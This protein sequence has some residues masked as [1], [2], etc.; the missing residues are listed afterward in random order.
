MRRRIDETERDDEA[1]SGRNATRKPE[2]SAEREIK[3]KEKTYNN[4]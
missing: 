3:G 4:D 1:T 2:E